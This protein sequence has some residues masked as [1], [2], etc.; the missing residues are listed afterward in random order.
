MKSDA[1]YPLVVFPVAENYGF[2]MSQII[3]DL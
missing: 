1:I 2:M 3:V